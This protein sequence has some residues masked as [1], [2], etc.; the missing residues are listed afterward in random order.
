MRLIEQYAGF[1]T[2]IMVALLVHAKHARESSVCVA[3]AIL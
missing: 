1:K 3:P 2:N